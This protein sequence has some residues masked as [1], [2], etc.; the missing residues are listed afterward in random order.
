MISFRNFV[1]NGG[2]G[3]SG[4][5][6]LA[7]AH[8]ELQQSHTVAQGQRQRTLDLLAS[9]GTDI[10]EIGAVLSAS[11]VA[12]P[13]QIPLP[14]S[15]DAV[16]KSEKLEEEFMVTK[17]HMSRLKID[18]RNLVQVRGGHENFARGDEHF[19]IFTFYFV[20]PP[21]IDGTGGDTVRSP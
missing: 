17:L 19:F 9:V 21:E 12:N 7:Q 14:F 4:Q 10:S 11:S 8:M 6:A 16:A 5:T 20:C 13:Y 15:L 1:L 2:F 3:F 18:I